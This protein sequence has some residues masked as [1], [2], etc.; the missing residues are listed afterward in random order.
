MYTYDESNYNCKI[1]CHSA[2]PNKKS[3]TIR[4]SSFING[5]LLMIK[6]LILSLVQEYLLQLFLYPDYYN[7]KPQNILEH[8]DCPL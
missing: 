7:L 6:I 3:L 4:L 1:Y 8:H 5:V 2:L